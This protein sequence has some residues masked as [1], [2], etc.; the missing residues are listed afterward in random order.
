MNEK[1]ELILLII[2]SLYTFAYTKTVIHHLH[3]SEMIIFPSPYG[4]W[5]ETFKFSLHRLVG[6]EKNKLKI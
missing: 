5:W 3:L 4:R 2:V 1:L 6:D